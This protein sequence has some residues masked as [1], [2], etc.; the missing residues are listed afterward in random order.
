MEDSISNLDNLF[1]TEPKK[2]FSEM[3]KQNDVIEFVEDEK[4]PEFSSEYWK[5]L[6]VDDERDIH[7][8]TD[9]VL[10]NYSFK[11]KKV[12]ILNAYSAKE[13]TEILKDNLDVAIVLLDVVMETIDAG[14]QFVKIIRERFNLPFLRIVLRTGQP[15]HAPEPEVI[16][17]YDINDYH[18]KT[19]LTHER[20]ITVITAGLRTYDSLITVESYRKNLEL[21]V[22]ER[23]KE[24]VKANEDLIKKNIKIEEQKQELIQINLLKDKMFSIIA[25]DLKGPVGNF[26]LLIDLI[27]QSNDWSDEEKEEILKALQDSAGSTLFLLENLLY[28]ARSQREEIKFNMATINHQSIIN[29]NI[30]LLA[31]SA[32]NKNIKIST[33]FIGTP[34]SYFDRNSISTVVRN[35]L[36]N[37]IKFTNQDGKIEISAVEM[38][39]HIVISVNDNGVG[40]SHESIDKL[41]NKSIYFSTHG[42]GN[43][44]GSGLGLSICLE[45]VQKNGGKIWVESQLEK[46]STFYFTLPKA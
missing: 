39:N 37:A 33:S 25:H 7:A 27:I 29:E 5:L 26:K 45:F 46:G 21:L 13:A 20:L 24:L 6:V 44:K 43:E 36:S 15:G 22:Q 32:K 10:T 12:K 16:T 35:L 9:I 18:T 1:S 30:E 3:D 40:I 42:T 28:W 17:K 23:T 19:E 31:V 8:I 14:F 41:F 38:E 4:L 11:N 2:L 34:N